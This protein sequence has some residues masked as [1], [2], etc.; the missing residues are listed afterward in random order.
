M[1]K[2]RQRYEGNDIPRMVYVVQ[3]HAALEV[4]LVEGPLGHRNSILQIAT[5]PSEGSHQGAIALTGE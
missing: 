1:G 5:T 3:P 4:H 2:K